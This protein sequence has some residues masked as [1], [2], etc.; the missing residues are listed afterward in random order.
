MSFGISPGRLPVGIKIGP[1]LV[2]PVLQL[3]ESLATG[4]GAD[5][6]MLEQPDPYSGHP[7]FRHFDSI[8]P[9]HPL[10]AVHV[11]MVSCDA[12]PEVILVG[13]VQQPFADP[14]NPARYVEPIQAM[15]ALFPKPCTHQ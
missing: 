5:Q 9:K 14:L 10:H 3:S 11:G 8:I 1:K 6:S 12:L 15:A 4:L 2:Q 13:Q 7:E